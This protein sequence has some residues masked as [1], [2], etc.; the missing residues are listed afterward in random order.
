M[1]TMAAAATATRRKKRERK[2]SGWEGMKRLTRYRLIVPIKRSKH[3]PTYTA[4]GSLV[5]LVWAFTPLVGIQMYLVFMTWVIGRKVFK[6]D[7][8]LIVALAWTWV[9]NVA[10]MLPSYYI[11]YITGQIML[12]RWNDISGYQSFV[13]TWN[14]AFGDGDW[15]IGSLGHYLKMVAADQGLT[16]MIG[17]L[18]W[19]AVFGWIGYRWTLAFIKRRDERRRHLAKRREAGA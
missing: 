17:C 1:T 12:G 16:M 5:G 7:F 8:N 13:D 3:P 9:T 18:P 11:F 10:T 2:H 15:G 14:K 19:A 4:H 6:Y